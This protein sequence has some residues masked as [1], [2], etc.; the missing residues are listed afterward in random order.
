MSTKFS[1]VT[2]INLSKLDKEIEEFMDETGEIN[3]YL[4]MSNET[5]EKMYQTELAT[6]KAPDVDEDDVDQVRNA[7]KVVGAYK[8]FII[9]RNDC[10]SYGQV[11]IR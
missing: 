9:Y 6:H 4:F 3:P 1:I 8:G 10:L 5:F 7:N 11:E 2:E